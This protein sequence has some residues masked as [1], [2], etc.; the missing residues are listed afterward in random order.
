M[1]NTSSKLKSTSTNTRSIGSLDIITEGADTLLYIT[2]FSD[3]L[4]FMILSAEKHHFQL[5]HF[6]ILEVLMLINWAASTEWLKIQKLAM[7]EKRSTPLDT[8]NSYYQLWIK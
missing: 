1:L 5:L 2:N 8:S 4:G 7:L 3:D 6:L